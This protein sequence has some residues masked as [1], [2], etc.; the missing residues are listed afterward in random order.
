MYLLGQRRVDT[1]DRWRRRSNYLFLRRQ[2]NR[3]LVILEERGGA[4]V[5]LHEELYW[6]LETSAMFCLESVPTP[7]A[8]QLSDDVDELTAMASRPDDLLVPWHELKHLIG[9]L[10]VLAR[11]DLP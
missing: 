9:L 11:R 4:T 8:G 6:V 3:L 10:E 5:Q 1:L 2:L 7:S